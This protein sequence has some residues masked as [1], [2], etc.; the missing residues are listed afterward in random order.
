MRAPVSRRRLGWVVVVIVVLV[1]GA[2]ANQDG[3]GGSGDGD[4]VR[5]E[6]A[7]K[8]GENRDGKRARKRDRGRERERK[9]EREPGRPPGI[10][11]DAK[12]TRVVSVADG[13][14]VKLAGL[15]SSRIIGVDTPEVYGGVECYGREASAFTK[16]VLTP[17]RTVYYVHGTERT[18]R[19]GRDLV[20]LWLPS[21]KFFNALLLKRGFAVTLTIPPNVEYADLFRRLAARARKAGRGLWAPSTCGGDADAP[22][23]QSKRSGGGGGAGSGASAAVGS[24]AGG[25]SGSGCEPG[26]SPCVPR[27]PPDLDCADVKG[28]IR[29]TGRDPHNLDGDGDGVA[30]E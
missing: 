29:V 28:P 2:I 30:C 10:P 18:D 3:G 13:D 21:G 25:R 23:S 8:R 19:Y 12:R 7:E 20:Y 5:P 9:R 22:A 4:R 15:G 24:G 16:S 1:I 26:Y 14:T 6:R 27:Y 11:S 17:G